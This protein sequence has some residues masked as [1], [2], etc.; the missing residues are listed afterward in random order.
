[1]TCRP[2]RASGTRKP[3]HAFASEREE[4]PDRAWAGGWFAWLLLVP[5]CWGMYTT[6]LAFLTPRVGP[7]WLAI[8]AVVGSVLMYASEPIPGLCAL[9]VAGMFLVLLMRHPLTTA[10]QP[11]VQP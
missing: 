3:S 7:W 9:W 6:V 5:L 10:E 11:E 1:M 4:S 2:G 8:A